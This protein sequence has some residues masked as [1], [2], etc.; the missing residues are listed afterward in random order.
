MAIQYELFRPEGQAC[1]TLRMKPGVSMMVR[2]GQYAYLQKQRGR[3]GDGEGRQHGHPVTTY[4][5]C[6]H[7][8]HV[9]VVACLLHKAGTVLTSAW[10]HAAIPCSSPAPPSLTRPSSRWAWPRP[11]HPPVCAGDPRCAG[12]WHQPLRSRAGYVGRA[13]VCEAVGGEG[14]V[15]EIM[16]ARVKDLEPR[17]LGHRLSVVIGGGCGSWWYA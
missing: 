11:W 14:G 12:R 13:G 9:T 3:R 8:H 16:D 17:A 2:L 6:I 15:L 7:G 1:L 4:Q 5:D 10:V